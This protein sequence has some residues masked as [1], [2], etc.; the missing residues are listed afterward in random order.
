MSQQQTPLP[1]AAISLSVVGRLIFMFLLYKNKSTNSLS[2][3]FCLL[4]MASSGMW[5]YYST[6][7]HDLPLTLRSCTEIT[8]LTISSVYIVRN[9]VVQYY[10]NNSILPS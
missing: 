10:N 7:Q 3:V 5:I 4:N 6:T 9:K 1:Y 8:L 2:L